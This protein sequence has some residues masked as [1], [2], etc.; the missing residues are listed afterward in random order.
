MWGVL[1]AITFFLGF[2]APFLWLL[3]VWFLWLDHQQS[4][5]Q[6]GLVAVRAYARANFE[7]S[8]PG[9]CAFCGEMNWSRTDFQ[10]LPAD[11]MRSFQFPMEGEVAVARFTCLNCGSFARYGRS[12][13]KPEQGW[14]MLDRYVG[15]W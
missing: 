8:H 12:L 15:G 4:K 9:E 11:G 6:T 14:V 2:A 10:I 3:T 1:A 5:N 13:Y 7:R